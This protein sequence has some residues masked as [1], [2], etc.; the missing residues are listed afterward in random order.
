V[1]LVNLARTW[2]EVL[3]GKKDAAEVTRG[4]WAQIKEADLQTHADA[5]L[6]IYRDKVV[7]AFDIVGWERGED[8][9]V[10]F[11]VQASQQWLNLIGT[12]N[13][14]KPWV[15]GQ[16]RPIQVLPTEIL[17]KGTI[18]VENVP[19]G[20]RAVVGGYVLTTHE[21][22]SALLQVP[23]G[24]SVTVSLRTGSQTTT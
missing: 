10:V 3:A 17:T 7:T 6:G 16:G 18:P 22:G 4:E 15:Q 1:F 2:P 23:D 21:D 13:P 12:P 8:K 19:A 24:G 14:G 11:T 20:R 9:R 5:I